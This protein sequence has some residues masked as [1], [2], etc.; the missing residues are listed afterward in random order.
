M[1]GLV[2]SLLACA[3]LDRTMSGARFEPL[4]TVNGE[5]HCPGLCP[6][7]AGASLER[8]HGRLFTLG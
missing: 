3:P 7:L 2:F 4:G 1:L 8:H 6:R 5:A